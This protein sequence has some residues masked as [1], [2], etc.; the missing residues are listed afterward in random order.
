MIGPTLANKVNFLIEGD[1]FFK[2]NVS[3]DMINLA[4]I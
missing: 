1:M 4:L 2:L 3:V